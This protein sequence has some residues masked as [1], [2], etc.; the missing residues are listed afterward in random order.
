M[1]GVKKVVSSPLHD[2]KGFIECQHGIIP[3]PVPAVME[4][5][6]NSNI[7]LITEDVNTELVT[8]TGMGLI[9][10]LCSEFGNMPAIIVDRIGYGFG[11][12][13]T[14]RLNALRVTLGTLYGE[15]RLLEEIA[16][17][18]TNIDNMNPEIMGYTLEKLILNGALDA[19]YTPVYMKKNRPAYMLTV[20]TNK[21]N[22]QKLVDIILRETTTLGIRRS[23]TQRYC[24]DREIK[25]VS[26]EY[27]EVRVKIASDGDNIKLAPEYEDCREI[28]VKTGIPIM[29]VYDIVY[30]KSR[31]LV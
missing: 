16:I 11:K 1:L 6:A 21:E 4:M 31:Y 19:F 10:C 24:M 17:L 22:E 28:A 18:E 13:E 26:T 12:R 30:E 3:V 27:G 8:P 14:G 20:L 9:K 29:K 2:G 7:P 25:S 23:L 15:D 5:L